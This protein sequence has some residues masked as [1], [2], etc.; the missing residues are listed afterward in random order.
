MAMALAEI[1]HLKRRARLGGLALAIF[2]CLLYNATQ[3]QPQDEAASPPKA[4]EPQHQTE[5]LRVS[6]LQTSSGMELQPRHQSEFYR[7]II[8]NN[9][10]R[11][12]GWTPPRPKEPYR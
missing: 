8:D 3:P 9:L 6:P 4:S 10:F 1:K 2:C 11:P 7:T 12:L 5:H